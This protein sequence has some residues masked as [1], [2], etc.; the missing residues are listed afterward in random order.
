MEAHLGGLGADRGAASGGPADRW[1]PHPGALPHWGEPHAPT[2]VPPPP[3]GSS[4]RGLPEERLG[5][6]VRVLERFYC[7]GLKRDSGHYCR[8]T[9]PNAPAPPRDPRYG[10]PGARDPDRSPVGQTGVRHRGGGRRKRIVQHTHTYSRTRTHIYTDTHTPTHART[11]A[12]THTHTHNQTH[13]S[14]HMAMLWIHDHW[15]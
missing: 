2:G 11:Y 3:R 4:W 6:G 9:A 8:A 10:P 12:C 7:P 1:G 14:L 13:T 5:G 15:K